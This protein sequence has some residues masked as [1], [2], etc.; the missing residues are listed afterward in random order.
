MQTRGR[1]G[2]TRVADQF[3]LRRSPAKRPPLRPTAAFHVAR[4][5]EKVALWACEDLLGIHVRLRGI[6]VSFDVE[7]VIRSQGRKSSSVV[8]QT[9]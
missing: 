3:S 1:S 8:S 9:P 5:A 2:A 6:G 7:F 4:V